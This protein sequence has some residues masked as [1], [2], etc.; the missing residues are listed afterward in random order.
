MLTCRNVPAQ[1]KKALIELNLD[2]SVAHCLYGILFLS[3]TRTLVSD[4]VQKGLEPLKS[5]QSKKWHADT[6]LS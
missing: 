2:D 5:C 4:I 1:V 3:L 6:E